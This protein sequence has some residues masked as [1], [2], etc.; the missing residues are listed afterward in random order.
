MLR[1]GTK[2]N[3]N[4]LSFF[5]PKIRQKGPLHWEMRGRTLYRL[6]PNCNQRACTSVINKQLWIRPLSGIPSVKG[7]SPGELHREHQTQSHDFGPSP[8]LGST[9]KALCLFSLMA[10]FLHVKKIYYYVVWI[11][12]LVFS[13]SIPFLDSHF[14]PLSQG[15]RNETETLIIVNWYWIFRKHQ[16]LC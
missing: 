12:A 1:N 14:L 15:C 11:S 2:C 16:A 8:G 6:P 5:G 7:G 10:E 3:Q 13:I 4:S 9:S